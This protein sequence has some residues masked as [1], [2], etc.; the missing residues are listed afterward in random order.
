M[1]QSRTAFYA[2]PGMIRA[3]CVDLYNFRSL[4]YFVSNSGLT[5]PD[6]LINTLIMRYG[7]IVSLLLCHCVSWVSAQQS[8]QFVPTSYSNQFSAQPAPVLRIQ[9]GDTVYTT[10][11]DAVGVDQNGIKVA[12]RGNP[13]TGPFF[14]QSSDAKILR[15]LSTARQIFK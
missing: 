13:L 1:T 9:Q 7:S 3:R 5:K 8:I 15:F 6:I 4:Y 12:K 11:V 10:S 2:S 14:I